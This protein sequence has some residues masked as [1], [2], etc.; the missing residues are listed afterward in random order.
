[1]DYVKLARVAGASSIRIMY[2]H[3]LPGT[4]N[5]IIVIATLRV[6]LVILVEAS[7]SF[8]GAGMPPNIPT[9]GL[10]VSEGRQFINSSWW[11]SFFPGIAIFLVVMSF[12]FLGD[13][14]RDK[15]DPR[16][17]QL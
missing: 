14:L 9:W 11:I 17:R 16:L 6:G 12:N 5:T 8:L 2:K 13:W 10:M 1:M 7:L 3:I 15:F 4:I